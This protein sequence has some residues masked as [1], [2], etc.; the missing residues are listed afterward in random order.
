MRTTSSTQNW[1]AWDLTMLRCLLDALGKLQRSLEKR[2]VACHGLIFIRNDVYELLVDATPDRGKVARANIDWTDPDLLRE[3]L[4]RRI[5]SQE[6]QGDPSFEDLW[7]QVCVS[8]IDGEESSQYMIDRS[9]MRPRNLIDLVHLCRSHAVN[10]GKERIEVD[11]IRRG[12]EAYSTELVSNISYEIRDVF[13]DGEDVLYQLLESPCQLTEEQTI[14]ILEATG[15]S[16]ERGDELLE[17]F[18]WYGVF[19]VIRDGGEIAYIY[20]VNYDIK[21][22]RALSRGIAAG[23]AVFYVNPAFWAGLE[24]KH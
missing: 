7:G 23:A 11:D 9:L 17:L 12:E 21:R 24:V 19:G 13:P 4:R 1:F 10:L 18:L 14:A 16:R 8:H 22:L 2:G 3:M 15:L 5:A 6:V 20:S